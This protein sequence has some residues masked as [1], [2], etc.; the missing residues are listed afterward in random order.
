MQGDRVALSVTQFDPKQL[1]R[2]LVCSPGA[3]ATIVAALVSIEK[4]PHYKSEI[5][6]KSK[7]HI[8][9]GHE[10][11]MAHVAVFGLYNEDS[12]AIN[13]R[14]FDFS[15]EYKYQECLLKLLSGASADNHND[16]AADSPT[17]QYALLE[18][19]RPVIC[20]EH[21]LVIGA[22]LDMDVH[23]TSCRLAF[24]GRILEKM[25]DPKYT[26]NTLPQLHIYKNKSR[27]GVVERK[28]D[29]YSVVCRGFFKKETNMDVFIGLK[30]TLSSGESGVIESAFGQSGKFKV[31]IPG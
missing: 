3:L 2:G 4:I 7:F 15:K 27:E 8:T 21:S 13:E 14:T 18:F 5:R 25:T 16:D 17:R 22:R 12:N 26:V 24:H 31:R 1:E 6:T 28:G 19:E 10:T 20:P 11:V 30:V 29:D 9:L 23:T